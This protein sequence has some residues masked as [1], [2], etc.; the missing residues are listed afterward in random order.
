MYDTYSYQIYNWLKDTFFP[1]F[2]SNTDLLSNIL[3]KIDNILQLLQYG[4]Y[5]GV[6]AF[7]FWVVFTIVRPHFFKI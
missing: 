3:E 7:L 4:L 1:L 2:K 6:F 5:L